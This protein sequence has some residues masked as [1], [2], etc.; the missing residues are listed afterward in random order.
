MS[1]IVSGFKSALS[2]MNQKGE[3]LS[4][5]DIRWNKSIYFLA[6][7]FELIFFSVR[8]QFLPV[9][10]SIFGI[11]GWTITHAVHMAASLVIM[12]LWSYKFKHLIKISVAAMLIGF[13]PYIFLPYGTIT[14]FIFGVIGYAGLGG[15]V[16]G[17]R[18]GYAFACNNT[19]RFFGIIFMY[20]SVMF[21][22]FIGFKEFENI[23]TLYILPL[24]LL[25]ALSFCMLKFK[26]SDF[27]VKEE[28]T[29]ADA[30]GLYW[31][32]AFFMMYFAVDGYISQ[33][34]K[35][36]YDG[37]YIF[38]ILGIGIAGIILIAAF[39]IFRLNIWHLWNMFFLFAICMGVFAVLAPKIGGINLQCIFC[40]LTYI[41]WPL[42]IYT[43]GCAQRRFASYA[44][45][46]KCTLV[47]VI[48]SPITTLSSDLV[49]DFIP[50]QLPIIALCFVLVITII[51]LMFSPFSYKYLF[52][53][54]WINEIYK[55]DMT[56]LQ[57]KIEKADRMGNYGLTPRQKEVAG[58]LLQAKTRRQIAGELGLSES[59]VKMHTAELYKKLGI[60]SR[61]E[62][63]R[64]FGVSDIDEDQKAIE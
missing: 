11:S 36:S 3:A 22:K 29:K 57:E 33:L 41:G 5:S 17:A 15:V 64:L 24:G 26:E 48:L 54:F 59:T 28:T 35:D 32:F 4:F 58:L 6:Y 50:E 45:L 43:M 8:G 1:E 19:E 23:F 9:G 40:G 30:S 46:K 10:V 52:S 60:N 62:L 55:S 18:C 21:V 13:I 47:Y 53:S 16:T 31:A 49:G 37:E 34:L 27:N 38:N 63:F 39:C 20:F 2:H 44:L 56:P 12:L 61:T 42:C 25:A 14:R 51:M 7:A